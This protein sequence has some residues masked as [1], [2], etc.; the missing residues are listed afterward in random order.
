MKI[1][2]ISYLLLVLAIANPHQKCKPLRSFFEDVQTIVQAMTLE[3][4]IGQM[5]QGDIPQVFSDDRVDP[6]KISEYM[7]GS[8]LI[9]ANGAPGPNG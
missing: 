5:T 4:K 6:S 2:L 3:Q 1:V 8:L 7:L 9:A